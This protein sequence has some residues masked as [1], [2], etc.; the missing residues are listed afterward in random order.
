MIGMKQ[1]VNNKLEK[2]I[3]ND[4]IFTPI[5]SIYLTL[6]FFIFRP[7]SSTKVGGKGGKGKPL[8]LWEIQQTLGRGDFI[9]VSV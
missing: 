7:N 2:L 8:Q 1:K 9:E 4:L 3:D 5:F 6:P